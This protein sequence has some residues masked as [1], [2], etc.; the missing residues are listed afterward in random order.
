MPIAMP[1]IGEKLLIR[2]PNG[3]LTSIIA[4]HSVEVA[5]AVPTPW[6]A[7]AKISIITESAK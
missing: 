3:L 1:A 4:E 7:R 6:T 2:E 5:N